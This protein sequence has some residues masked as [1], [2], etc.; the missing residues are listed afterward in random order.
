MERR[1]DYET[2]D[3]GW[4]DCNIYVRRTLSIDVPN[5]DTLFKIIDILWEWYEDLRLRKLERINYDIPS[6]K[7][8]KYKTWKWKCSTITIDEDGSILSW[9]TWSYHD[10]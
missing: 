5:T 2:L 1:I 9:D 3:K 4:G 6:I 10:A 7:K 8:P